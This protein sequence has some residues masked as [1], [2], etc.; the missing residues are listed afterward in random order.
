MLAIPIFNYVQSIGNK[1]E[2]ANYGFAVA[3]GEFYSNDT[4]DNDVTH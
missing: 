2:Y 3:L 4:F 1:F